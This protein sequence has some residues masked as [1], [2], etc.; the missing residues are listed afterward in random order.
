[1]DEKPDAMKAAFDAFNRGADDPM[2]EAFTSFERGKEEPKMPDGPQP[3]E[4][5]KPTGPALQ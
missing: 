4:K 2:K 5:V 1:M 3:A